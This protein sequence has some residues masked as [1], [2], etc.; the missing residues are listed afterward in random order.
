MNLKNISRYNGIM[1][2]AIRR[3]NPREWEIAKNTRDQHKM[4]AVLIKNK[5]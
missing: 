4:F 5:R 2:E 1:A 3:N